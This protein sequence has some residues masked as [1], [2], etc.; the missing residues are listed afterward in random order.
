MKLTTRIATFAF[1]ALSCLLTTA[2]F[3]AEMPATYRDSRV[4]AIKDPT[5]VR[6]YAFDEGAGDTI[7]SLAGTGA[8]AMNISANDPYYSPKLD[9]MVVLDEYPTWTVGRWPGKAALRVGKA[10]QSTTHSFLYNSGTKSFTVEVW[11]R[12]Y[13]DSPTPGQS[14]IATIGNGYDHGWR[15]V[16]SPYGAS[17]TL[18]RPVGS[19]PG[20][21]Q[22]GVVSNAPL[23]G[24]IWHQIVASYDG[25]AKIAALYVDGKEA[26]RQAIDGD[27]Q[28]MNPPASNEQT[29][30]LDRGGLA[31]GGNT[32]FR[33]TLP[34]DIDELVVY[35][36]ALPATAVAAQYAVGRPTDTEAAQ[37]AAH[38]ALIAERVALGSIEIGVPLGSG[39]FPVGSPVPLNVSIGRASGVTGK[40][41]VATQLV[42]NAGGQVWKSEQPIDAVAAVDSRVVVNIPAATCGLF[43]IDAKLIDSAGKVIKAQS[44][45][46]GI[47]KPLMPIA[48]IPLT[49][50]LAHFGGINMHYEDLGVGG[51]VER[52]LQPWTP[53]DATGKYDWKYP[54]MY[55][56]AATDNGLTIMYTLNAPCI[57]GG[58]ATFK[59][60]ADDLPA[61][62]KWIR[63]VITRYRDRVQY[64]EVLNEPNGGGQVTAS[65]Y[66]GLL[67]VANKVLRELDPTAKIVGVGGTANFVEWT[68]DVL[69]AGGGQYIDI[70]CFH[71]Y[72][73]TSPIA[74][75][76]LYHKVASVKAAIL[77]YIGHPIPMWNGEC[78]IHQPTRFNGRAMTDE[79]LLKFYPGRSSTKSGWATAG[80]DAIMMTTEH[81]SASWQ[82]ES[83]LIDIAE[84]A[85]K[86]FLLM[87]SNRYYP[88]A[89]STTQGL[90][91]EKGIALAA[92][93]S[94]T[95]TMASLT[96]IPLST[97]EAAALLVTDKSGARTAIFFADRK[98]SVPLTVPGATVL[99]GMDMLG[100]P[101]TWNA[102]RGRFTL[103]LG[104]E[105]VYL[106]NAPAGLA[107]TRMLSIGKFP[108]EV[109]P[110][111]T[112]TGEVVVTNSSD[113]P[114]KGTFVVAA[115]DCKIAPLA[116]VSL[117]AGQ[118]AT[119]PIS[120]QAGDLVRGNHVLSVQLVQGGAVVSRAEQ[121]F[122]SQ[123]VSILVPAT[124]TPIVLD[125]N[126]ADWA[127]IA[128]EKADQPSQVAIGRPDVGV[129]DKRWWQGPADLS[130]TVKT[131]WRDDA[132]YMLI[133]VTDN[134]LTIAPDGKER[135]GYIWD[136]IEL[137]F[138]GR[139]LE[140]QTTTYSP[141]AEQI[142]IVPR[143]GDTL[144]A[145]PV[146]NFARVAPT[147][148]VKF[149]GK[150]TATGYIMEGSIKPLPGSP[151]K[152]V[153]GTHFGMDVSIDDADGAQRRV[154]MPLHG[155]EKNSFDTSQWGRYELSPARTR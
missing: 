136:C 91:S 15:L 122:A 55:V 138:D 130:Y 114:L 99:R 104:E 12:A 65:E 14:V 6:F 140:N 155:T 121:V 117:A 79:E 82:V 1:A 153:P 96:Q 115:D 9:P 88:Y 41:R 146:V 87:G 30:E 98:M 149:V 119:V 86:Y 143:I 13:N 29:P 36:R 39:Y 25:D 72:L 139:A 107:E 64:W 35:N 20:K 89:M 77:K 24:H 132:V 137:F 110:R 131:T 67:K 102:T 94:V 28:Q 126:T 83:I 129:A 34:F 71:N 56:K 73:G 152:L 4:A 18:G 147:L 32:S 38:K 116:P 26:G 100:N 69:S 148:D 44:F 27:Y 45:P 42:D 57:P 7:K 108:A 118:T 97:R 8:G 128:G 46:I 93:A 76:N 61:W 123:G 142:I 127:G 11:F 111:S 101:L 52:I 19:G 141:G 53:V 10:P 22:I 23:A 2:A 135:L 85:E 51:T 133:D 80:V 95:N 125:C 103:E 17:I 16:A 60:M 37:I 144:A 58:F 40:L 50:P 106:F 74:S 21:G 59:N 78:G 81:R 5:V 120:L 63:E 90:P 109:S 43:R 134:Q 54:D 49:A 47:R 3:A 113:Q 105:P 84:G 62:E 48:Q 33:N 154:Q 145:C 66:V 124:K 31:V 92:M 151:F 70:L 75:R 68:E 150:R 112:V